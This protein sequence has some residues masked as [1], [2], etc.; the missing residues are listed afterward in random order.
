MNALFALTKIFREVFEDDSLAVSAD[1]TAD[2]VEDWD[3]VAQVKLV[4][5]TE[6]EFA[7]RFTTEEVAGLK[8]V[9]DFLRLI[10]KYI[11]G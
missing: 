2:Q 7:I 3:S 8:S 5:M 6:M 9:G 11:G 1:L 4:L 10:E